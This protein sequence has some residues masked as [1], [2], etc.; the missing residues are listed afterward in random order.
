MSK[1]T[2]AP[3]VNEP[4]NDIVLGQSYGYESPQTT[5]YWQQWAV[6]EIVQRETQKSYIGMSAQPLGRWNWHLADAFHNNKSTGLSQALRALGPEAF[7]FRILERCSD[8]ASARDREKWWIAQRVN[9]GADLFNTLLTIRRGFGP[10]GQ[11]NP[12]IDC[13]C[14]FATGGHVCP[15]Y[16]PK[17]RTRRQAPSA[18]AHKVTPEVFDV[19]QRMRRL[20]VHLRKIA[21][22]LDLSVGIVH[23]YVGEARPRPAKVIPLRQPGIVKRGDSR[24][25]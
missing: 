16:A 7:D 10:H 9:V 20:D 25:L 3:G 23:R 8:E 18:R 5:R 2:R 12:Y 19:M 4:A 17:Q 15:A 6:Y 24:L 1:V 22:A 14:S 21:E 11:G 13:D